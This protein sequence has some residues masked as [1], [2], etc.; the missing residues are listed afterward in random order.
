MLPVEWFELIGEMINIISHIVLIVS[1][2]MAPA[3]I[4]FED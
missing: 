3:S 4:I 2:L 1:L